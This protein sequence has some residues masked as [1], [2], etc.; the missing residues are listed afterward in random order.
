MLFNG[1][2]VKTHVFGGGNAGVVQG[3]TIVNA[4]A[5]TT[6][7]SIYGGGNLATVE[8]N[9]L[10]NIYGNIKVG[11]S[12]TVAPKQG[13]V[14]GGG[15]KAETGLEANGGSKNIVNIAGGEIFGNAYG[16]AN[17]SKVWG[18]T[19]VNIGLKAIQDYKTANPTVIVTN[20]ISK[21]N[22]VADFFPFCFCSF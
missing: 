20:K 22:N 13:S 1:G 5:G 17:T 16:G 8:N 12:S 3:S 6:E 19:V 15:N 10:V 18:S 14:F 2:T 4:K 11:N 21:S 9:T 7:G